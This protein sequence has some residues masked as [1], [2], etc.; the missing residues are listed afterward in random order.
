MTSILINFAF[1]LYQH[2]NT[3]FVF[4]SIFLTGLECRNKGFS[5][6]VALVLH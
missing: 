4:I 2:F 1:D 5:L 6:S 3:T